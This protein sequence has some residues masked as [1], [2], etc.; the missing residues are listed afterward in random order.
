MAAALALADLDGDIG[1]VRSFALSQRRLR[2]RRCGRPC[3]STTSHHGG[4]KDLGIAFH[5][6]SPVETSTYIL[7]QTVALVKWAFVWPYG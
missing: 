4:D 5:R 2:A 3:G 7:P 6:N 1:V